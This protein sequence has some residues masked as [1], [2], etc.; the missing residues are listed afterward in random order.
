MQLTEQREKKEEMPLKIET[1]ASSAFYMS[2]LR[3]GLHFKTFGKGKGQSD[4]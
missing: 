1:S 3:A 2:L 4:N